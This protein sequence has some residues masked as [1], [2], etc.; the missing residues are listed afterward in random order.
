MHV[1]V[2]FNLEMLQWSDC[3]SLTNTKQWKITNLLF[4]TVN[5]CDFIHE[6]VGLHKT[7]MHWKNIEVE[8]MRPIQIASSSYT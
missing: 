5:P 7:K 8:E 6:G 3:H 2:H 4:L 1:H